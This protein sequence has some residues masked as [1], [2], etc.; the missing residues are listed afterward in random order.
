M[1]KKTQSLL[2]VFIVIFFTRCASNEAITC[3]LQPTNITTNS[4][5]ITGD[6]ISLSTPIY[7]S[8]TET[9]QWSGPNGFQSNLRNPIISNSNTSMSGE[10]SLK[11]K[12]GICETEE[13]KS[14]VVV[15]TNSLNCNEPNN[16]GTFTNA[17]Y[18]ESFYY[19]SANAI[20]N[21]QFELLGSSTNW[22][23]KADFFGST[24]PT[25]GFY[26]IV[27][28]STP[29]TQNTVHLNSSNSNSQFNYY[30]KSGTV[31][32]SYNSGFAVIKFCSVPFSLTNSTST[33]F[34]CSVMFTQQ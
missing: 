18:D 25:T 32:V 5:V 21:N 4:P 8:G 9:Y 30:A 2:F 1:Y 28:S 29:L 17:L 23:I 20:I 19:F 24:T 31:S 33:Q 7:G 12:I 16:T 11:V 14:Q 34:S 26:T 22:V 15:L 6:Q 3:I 27:D 13:I 10:Y